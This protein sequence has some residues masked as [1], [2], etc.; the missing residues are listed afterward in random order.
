MRS[1]GKK[2][3][4]KY[5][6]CSI[7]RDS[8]ELRKVQVKKK[9]KKNQ[10]II[11]F[12]YNDWTTINPQATVQTRSLRSVPS[13]PFPCRV[14][15]A[16]WGEVEGEPLPHLTQLR[17][18]ETK[19]ITTAELL[20]QLEPA[21]PEYWWQ[22]SRVSPLEVQGVKVLALKRSLK[23]DNSAWIRVRMAHHTWG[24]PTCF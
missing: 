8:P 5:S 15:A 2:L 13:P 4:E 19:P 7:F 16:S 10:P 6:I 9:R 20:Q 3:S 11:I 14:Q 24:N 22:K 1:L 12:L 18:L 23:Q 17:H 21:S